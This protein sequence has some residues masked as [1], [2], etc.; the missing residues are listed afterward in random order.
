MATG[1]FHDIALTTGHY[2]RYTH[3]RCFDL[4]HRWAT[5]I[6]IIVV[7]KLCSGRVV[8]HWALE[9]KVLS[10]SL[11]PS[12]KFLGSFS[13]DGCVRVSVDCPA[14][15]EQVRAMPSGNSS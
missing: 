14:R 9:L 15:K 8:K 10:S 7:N 2:H 4:R 11:P 3:R 13:D 1:K 6:I 5:I 12:T